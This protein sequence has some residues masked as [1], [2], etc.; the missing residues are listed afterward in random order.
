MVETQSSELSKE[1]LNAS[2]VSGHLIPRNLAGQIVPVIEVNPKIVKDARVASSV[3]SDATSG[4][5]LIAN[6]SQEVYISSAMLSVVKD[7]A[8]TSDYARIT[9]TQLGAVRTI[10]Q[11]ALVPSSAGNAHLTI[12]F[13]HAIK[14]D[15][16]TAVNISLTNGTASVDAY[17]SITYF[18][19]ECSNA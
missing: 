4:A 18:V 19:D 10:L 15:R 14:I 8:N 1:I 7:A 5:I 17:G 13:P 2:K 9:C 16:N 11:L 12:S 3:V 6:S